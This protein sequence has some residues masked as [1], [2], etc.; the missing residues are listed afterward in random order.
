MR[1]NLSIC[2]VGLVDSEKDLKIVAE[3]GIT[4]RVVHPSGM[5]ARAGMN[6][7]ENKLRKAKNQKP[8]T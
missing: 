2:L 1:L 7:N 4:G 8:H 3:I 6:E 5:R